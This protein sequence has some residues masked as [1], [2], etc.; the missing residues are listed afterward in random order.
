MKMDKIFLALI[1]INGI[2]IDSLMAQMTYAEEVVCSDSAELYGN[3]EGRDELNVNCIS[4]VKKNA[5]PLAVV[6][7]AS[8]KVKFYGHKNIIIADRVFTKKIDGKDVVKNITD[9]IA[10]SNTEL[11]SIKSLILDEANEE[12]VVLEKNGDIFF[13]TSKFSGNIAPLRI[14]RHKE[15]VEADSIAIDSQKN[16]IVI[17]VSK[18]RK[19]YFFSRLANINAPKEKQKLDIIRKEDL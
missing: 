1:L 13:F 11:K 15:I 17:T 6:D 14:L 5:E 8:L 16:E 18:H 2:N 12:L 9:V 4:S 10:G 3:G 7:S 19:R